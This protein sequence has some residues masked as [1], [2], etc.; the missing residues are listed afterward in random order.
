MKTRDLF[1]T[2][3][4]P[5]NAGVVVC[6]GAGVDST[7]MLLAMHDQGIRP[8]LITFADTGGEKPETYTQ[9]DKMDAWLISKGWPTVTWCKLRTT[10]ATSYNTLEGNNTD[11]C[12]LPSL[13]MGKKGCSMKWKQK[14][15]DDFLK[16][17]NAKYDGIEA[18]PA[19]LA[20]WAQPHPLWIR[21]QEIGVKLVKL[22]GYDSSPADIRRSKKVKTEDSDF[23]YSYPLQDLGWTR[24]DCIARIIREGLEVPIKSACWFCPASQKWELF[25]LAGTHPD[26]FMKALAMEHAAMMGKHSRWGKYVD[27]KGQEFID[28][29]TYGKAWVEFVKKPAKQWPTTSITVGLGRSFSW[30]HWARENGI[31][32][33]DGEFIENSARYLAKADDLKGSGGNA[34]DARRCA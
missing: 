16:G 12:T 17:V 18:L 24:E 6:Y 29:A 10:A 23:L 31:V 26:L 7:A 21:S 20:N 3:D 27:G 9:V 15:Q 8:D 19:H 32:T 14:P 2:I 22:I 34:S 28:E 33:R 5:E 11:N 13:A 1:P 30:N 25:W 4:L